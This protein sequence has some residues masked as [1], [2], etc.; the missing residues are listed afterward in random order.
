MNLS[1]FAQFSKRNRFFWILTCLMVCLPFFFVRYVPATDL[2]QHLG[3]IKLFIEHFSHS[4]AMQAYSINW[5]GA[6][7]LVYILLGIDWLVFS[8]IAAGKALMLELVCMW[9]LVVFVLAKRQHR[10][11]QPAAFQDSRVRSAR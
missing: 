4:K 9:V 10:T 8:P 7:S 6:N 2:P 5:S 11:W 3:Q 1:S